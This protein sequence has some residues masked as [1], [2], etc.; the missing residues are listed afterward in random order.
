M[1]TLLHAQNKFYRGVGWQFTPFSFSELHLE[2][3]AQ[4]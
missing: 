2:E 4:S 3:Q 1:P